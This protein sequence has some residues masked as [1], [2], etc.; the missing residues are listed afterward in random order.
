MIQER[1]DLELKINGQT[2][3]SS[4]IMHWVGDKLKL[5]YVKDSQEE[6][7]LFEK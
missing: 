4:K 2:V 5:V 7:V 3:H 6:Q 1:Y